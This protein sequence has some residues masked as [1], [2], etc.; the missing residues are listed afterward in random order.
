MKPFYQQRK[1]MAFTRMQLKATKLARAGWGHRLDVFGFQGVR[2]WSFRRCLQHPWRCLVI[3]SARHRHYGPPI[4]V[5]AAPAHV[6]AVRVAGVQR[7]SWRWGGV[8]HLLCSSIAHMACS[9]SHVAAAAAFTLLAGPCST[10]AGL[11]RRP[12]TATIPRIAPW[13][14]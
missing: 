9:S 4:F 13:R 12:C 7:I 1:S 10:G 6:S 3:I 11:R 5:S 14:G 8:H 2:V